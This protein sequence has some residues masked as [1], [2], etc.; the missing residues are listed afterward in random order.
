MNLLFR[1]LAAAPGIG[2]GQAVLYRT[3]HFAL[4]PPGAPGDPSGAAPDVPPEPEREWRRFLAAQR[5]VDEELE[6]L[7][8]S[9]HSLVAEVFVAHRAILQ[10][11]MLVAAARRG[12]F[13]EGLP[14]AG[15][16]LQAVSEMAEL[17][18]ALDDDYFAGR[19]SDVLD[20]GQ[21]LLAALGATERRPHLNALPPD[22]ILLVDELT[23]SDTAQLRPES[24]QGIALAGGT[25]T[26]HPAILARSLGIPLVCG[27]GPGVLRLQPQR[28]TI[29]DGDAGLLIVDPSPAELRRYHA[30]R[31][32]RIEERAQAARH[33]HAPAVTRDGRRV[34]VLA[35]ANSPEE[36][37]S[38]RETGAEGVGLL[39]TEYLFQE[40][41]QPPSL[42]EQTDAYVCFLRQVEPGQL[43]VRALD[44]GG[45]KPVRFYAHPREDNPFL[46]LRGIRL[47]IET[48]ELLRTQYHALQ[49]AVQTV[50]AAGVAV[51]AR[52][53]LPMVTTLEE[54]QVARGLLAGLDQTL[55]PLPLGVMVEVPSAALIARALAAHADFLSIGT[56]DLAQYTLASDR[57]HRSVGALAD[58]LHPAVLQLIAQTCAAA[59]TAG[60]P[61]SLCG[62]LAG[63]I[64]A[65]P[66]LLGLGV[67]ELSMPLPAVAL[68]KEAVRRTTMDEARALAERALACADA[69]SVRALLQ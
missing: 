25:P 34:R 12:V 33:A 69:A 48:P 8:Q 29:V 47:L 27:L 5:A 62:E 1:G 10:D 35:N 41:A 60:V 7:G 19:A 43:T 40:R 51:E 50:R 55:P 57:T 28:R 59:E 44:A 22:T 39:R 30:E 6:R 17:L 53:L 11:E 46:G 15:A 63:N 56:N 32:S 20:I 58:P 26:A 67:Q 14:V 52:F 66:L 31:Q 36:M 45:D 38:V 21:R 37:I 3:G 49:Q 9:A 68:V 4:G 61:V 13:D 65:A 64:A 42:A 2:I 54:L 18:A 23:P 24:V 16:T